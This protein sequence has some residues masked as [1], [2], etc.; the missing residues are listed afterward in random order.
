M[1]FHRGQQTYLHQEALILFF[2][3]WNFDTLK[4]HKSKT[5]LTL[6]WALLLFVAQG[7][8][9]TSERQIVSLACVSCFYNPN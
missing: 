9:K 5:M 8:S 2:A 7:L 4:A 6:A 1:L 3:F